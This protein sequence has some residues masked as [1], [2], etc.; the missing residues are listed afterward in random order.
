MAFGY[1]DGLGDDRLVEYDP[2][3]HPLSYVNVTERRDGISDDADARATEEIFI[4]DPRGDRNPLGF[5][6]WRSQRVK[7]SARPR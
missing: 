4:T 5:F 6:V 3:K 2:K 7:P 1:G